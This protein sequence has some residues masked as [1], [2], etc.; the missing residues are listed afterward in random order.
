MRMRIA[1]ASAAVALAVVLGTAAAASAQTTTTGK[2]SSGESKSGESNSGTSSSESTGSSSEPVP[3]NVEKAGHNQVEA[4]ECFEQQ[5]QASTPDFYRC[6]QAPSPLIPAKNEIIW[7]SIAFFITLIA[8]W[9][10]AYPGMKKGMENRSEKIR[11]DLQAA[12]DARIEAEQLKADY[13]QRLAAAKS[14]ATRVI[15]DARGT[16][17]ALKAELQQRAEADIAEM[18]QR[19]AADADA[20]KD[21]IMAD[22][23]HEVAQIAIQAAEVVVEK[24]LD[25]ATQMQLVENYIASVGSKN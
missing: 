20:M 15:E 19:A 25:A 10:F 5:L 14:E 23:Q 24:N 22:L 7:G 17:D 8:L 9:K 3:A 1:V 21:Q 13:E 12:E 11:V 16:A 6:G 4:F 2:T 18:R